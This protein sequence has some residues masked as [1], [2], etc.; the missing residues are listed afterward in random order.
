MGIDLFRVPAAASDSALILAVPLSIAIC[1]MLS[2][3]LARFLEPGLWVFY[4]IV[5]AACLLLLAKE[6]RRR[7]G[8]RFQNTSGSL[9][10]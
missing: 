3:L 1:P 9:W 4:I 10:A 6:A 2:Y 7:N 8:G 5:F